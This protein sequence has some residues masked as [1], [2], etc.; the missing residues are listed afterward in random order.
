MKISEYKLV[1]GI[2]YFLSHTNNVGI[3]K[4]FKLLYFWD[5]S[6]FKKYGTSVTGLNYF[7]Y[8]FGPVPKELYKQIESGKIAEFIIN[9]FNVRKEVDPEDPEKYPQY[10][11]YIKD[12][13]VDLDW[14]SPNE[15]KVLEDVAYIYKNSPAREMSDI[16]HLKGTPYDKTKNEKGMFE[17]IDYFFSLDDESLDIDLIK[18]RFQLQKDLIADGRH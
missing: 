10:K 6:H 16:T 12:K 8:P 18:E 15:K 9:N 7:T 1:N 14:L 3:T 5:Y 11:F 2:K 13:K 17:E 4:L